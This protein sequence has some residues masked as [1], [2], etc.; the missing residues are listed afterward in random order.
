MLPCF[1]S[2][3][4]KYLN[5]FYILP[6]KTFSSE[7]YLKELENIKKQSKLSS[8][9]GK[10]ADSLS[11]LLA[12]SDIPKTYDNL[13]YVNDPDTDGYTFPPVSAKVVA[14]LENG[15]MHTALAGGI[16]CGV[17]LDR[18]NFYHSAGG[19]TCDVGEILVSSQVKTNKKQN[20]LYVKEVTKVG[21]YVI[22]FGNLN[23]T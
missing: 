4:S 15:N 6:G 18:T 7:E 16:E 5:L 14:L 19:Q 1:N 21:D 10:T 22:H 9:S 3:S 13:K 12:S 2:T 8:S 20:S 11:E 23:G 17:V